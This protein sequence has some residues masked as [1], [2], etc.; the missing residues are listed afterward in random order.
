LRS[1]VPT[2]SLFEFWMLSFI[3]Q[4]PVASFQLPVRSP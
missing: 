3:K 4:F 1:I 2:V